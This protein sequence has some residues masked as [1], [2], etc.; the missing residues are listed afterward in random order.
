M[1]TTSAPEAMKTPMELGL[2][3]RYSAIAPG[4]QLPLAEK[5]QCFSSSQHALQTIPPPQRISPGLYRHD[6]GDKSAPHFTFIEAT[7]I[8]PLN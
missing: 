5:P 7:R 3:F 4:A 1:D 2:F 6:W 8:L